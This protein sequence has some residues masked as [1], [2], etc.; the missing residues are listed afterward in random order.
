MARYDE[1]FSIN[2]DAEF[3][4][5]ALRLFRYQAEHCAPYAEYLRLIGVDVSMVDRVESIPMLP[6][7]LFKS[8]D[9]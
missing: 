7:E 6:I 2:S 5:E 1:I 4:R 8:H 3:E 9:V